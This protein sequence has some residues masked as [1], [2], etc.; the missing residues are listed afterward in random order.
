MAK[1]LCKFSY[2]TE[3]MKGLLSEGGTSRRQV[4]EKLAS[5]LG[6]SIESFYYA[7]GEDDG[8][9]IA[10]FPSNADMAAVSLAVGAAGGA[11]LTTIALM[12]PEEIDAAAKKTVDYRAPGK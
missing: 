7:L 9:L 1:Y 8:Y 3:G 5:N 10:D 2:T 11:T 6:G 4:V 12:T